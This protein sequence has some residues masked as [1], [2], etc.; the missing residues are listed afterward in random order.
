M[1]SNLLKIAALGFTLLSASCATNAKDN[2]DNS[3]KLTA[4][5][6]TDNLPANYMQERDAFIKEVAPLIKVHEG[7]HLYAYK[8]SSDYLTACY[9]HFV[10]SREDFISLKWRG[11]DGKLLSKKEKER[12][13]YLTKKMRGNYATFEKAAKGIHMTQKDATDLLE[14]ELKG[15]YDRMYTRLIKKGIDLQDEKIPEAAKLVITDVGYNVGDGGLM[16][17]RKALKCL[18]NNNYSS[19]AKEIRITSTYNIVRE[20]NKRALAN[21]AYAEQT[22]KD[23]TRFEAVLSENGVHIPLLKSSAE[24]DSLLAYMQP[25]YPVQMTLEQSQLNLD[26]TLDPNALMKRYPAPLFKLNN[27]SRG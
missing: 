7:E 12:Y 10:T 2:D 23:T 6:K 21:I 11:K 19:F 18:K 16:K 8:D 20:E 3:S 1:N 25:R 4:V 26:N 22:G 27:S 5:S 14:S 17:F 15:L 24:K 13:Y 9:G